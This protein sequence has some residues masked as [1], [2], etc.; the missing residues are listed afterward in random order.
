[1]RPGTMD[2]RITLERLTVT[3]DPIYGTQIESWRPLGMVWAEVRQ[4][5]GREFLAR[6]MM[7]AQKRV[8]FY[9][10][11]ISGLTILDRVEFEGTLH[12]IQEV[13]EIGRRDGVELHTVAS[14]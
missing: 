2:R 14:A 9:L 10:R 7:M 1:M 3:T 4:Q 12:N 6:D 13:R 5:G 8:V 11:W